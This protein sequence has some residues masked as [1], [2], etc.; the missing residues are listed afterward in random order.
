MPLK[1]GPPAD[2]VG[3]FFSISM[4][5]WPDAISRSATTVGLS[6]ASTF[7]RVPLHQLARAVGRRERELEAV[8]DVFQTIFDGNTR[9]IKST[10]RQNLCD[11]RHFTAGGPRPR[12]LAFSGCRVR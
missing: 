2:Q 6:L 12:G 5:T 7:G 10:L 8:R 1:T 3:T 9:H 4:P 11:G